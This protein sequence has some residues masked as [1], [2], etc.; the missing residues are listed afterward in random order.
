M[1]IVD[2]IHNEVA[3]SIYQKGVEEAIADGRLNSNEKVFLEKLQRDLRLPDETAQ[4]IYSAKAK[5]YL[6][7]YLKVA[8]SDERFSPGEEKEINAIFESLGVKIIYDEETKSLLNRYRLYWIIEN[9]SLTEIEVGIKLQ[10]DEKCYFDCDVDWHEYRSVTRPVQYVGP[11]L[12]TKSARD[13]YCRMSD[14][15]VQKISDDLLNYINSGRLFL[16]NKRLIFMGTQNNTAIEL[17]KI[18]DFIPYKNGVKIQ[19]ESGKI[20]FLVFDKDIDIFAV[21]LG[22]VIQDFCQS[23]IPHFSKIVELW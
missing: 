22:R 11:T 23:C 20:S 13:F 15:D 10:R 21:T 16:T 2:E 5:E 9:E 3:A 17:T 7:R 14:L 19:E 4:R 6:E 12:R 1:A 18:L 8:I